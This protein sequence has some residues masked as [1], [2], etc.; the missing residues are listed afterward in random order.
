MR[1]CRLTGVE[2]NGAGVT[3]IFEDGARATGDLLIAADGGQSTIRGLLAPAVAPRYAGY[4]AW[5][6]VL[7]ESELEPEQHDALFGRMTFCLPRGQLM[8]GMSVPGRDGDSRPGHRRYYWIWYRIA[9]RAGGL[10]EIFTDASG[11]DHGMSIAPHLLRPEIIQ[12]LRDAAPNS[13]APLLAGMVTRT[14]RPFPSAIFD[15]EQDQLVFGRVA[16]LGD[17]AFI[18]R[19]HIASGV[20]KAA[21]DA[22]GLATALAGESDV[23]AA[24]A[25]YQ[26]ERVAYGKAIVARARHLGAHLEAMANGETSVPEQN[27]EIV[28]KEYGTAGVIGL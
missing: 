14:A 3:A 10:R 28:L 23:D 21:L 26:R 17:S 18:A 1:G 27:P 13:M 8:L 11:R 25:R 2:Q 5:R 15:L 20:T 22:R 7:D 19:P 4:A 9:P 12:E 24:L 6:G 16:L